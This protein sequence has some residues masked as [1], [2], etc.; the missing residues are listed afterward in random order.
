MITQGWTRIA[1]IITPIALAILLS[2]CHA[3]QV[4]APHPFTTMFEHE[5]PPRSQPL[6]VRAEDLFDAEPSNTQTT[7]QT[8]ESVY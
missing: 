8:T 6:T 7:W 3:V 1:R 5:Q 4:G 2:G